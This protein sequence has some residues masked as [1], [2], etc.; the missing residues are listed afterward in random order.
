[1]SF[2]KPLARALVTDTCGEHEAVG[3]CKNPCDF[4]FSKILFLVGHHHAQHLGDLDR[5]IAVSS[6]L[7]WA[8]S[9]S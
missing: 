6:R 2:E 1:M 3:T 7:S 9:A 8:A 4:W 5:K